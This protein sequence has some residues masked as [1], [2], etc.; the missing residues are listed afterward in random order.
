MQLAAPCS[1]IF[2]AP[3]VRDFPLRGGSAAGVALPSRCSALSP[4]L[5]QGVPPALHLSDWHTCHHL[6]SSSLLYLNL[7]SPA[8]HHQVVV[9]TTVV[10]TSL[11]TS[12]CL[13]NKIPS[14][15]NLRVLR[16]PGKEMKHD[17]EVY[18]VCAKYT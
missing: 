8:T 17:T 11:G 6:Q 18:F 15:F 13:D 9:L 14:V 4:P 3:L 2:D 12:E 5:R 16:A 10:D 1:D 7:G